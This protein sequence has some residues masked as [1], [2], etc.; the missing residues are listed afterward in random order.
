MRPLRVPAH[1]KRLLDDRL[2]RHEVDGDIAACFEL[3]H[4]LLR[5]GGR[6]V[7]THHA[8]TGAG[9]HDLFHGFVAGDVI[10]FGIG[11]GSEGGGAEREER[12]GAISW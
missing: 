2:M 11:V 3:L 4:C 1:I 10:R 8:A 5:R 6:C 7:I 9:L 12:G